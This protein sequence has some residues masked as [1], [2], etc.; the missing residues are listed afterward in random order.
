MVESEQL[1]SDEQVPI[2]MQSIAKLMEHVRLPIDEKTGRP[3]EGTE[4][5]HAA[6][7]DVHTWLIR[8]QVEFGYVMPVDDDTWARNR[9]RLARLGGC[10]DCRR[11]DG[12]VAVNGNSWGICHAHALR[13]RVRPDA[14]QD[15]FVPDGTP[16]WEDPD[17]PVRAYAVVKA[18]D[19][20][21][22]AGSRTPTDSEHPDDKP[23]AVGGRL[24]LIYSADEQ[25]KR[26]QLPADGN[27][28]LPWPFEVLVWAIVV[29]SIP[30][31]V[32]TV[33]ALWARDGIHRLL[34]ADQPTSTG[35]T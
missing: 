35:P 8:L 24:K 27:T 28:P 13:W 21:S 31:H 4:D 26:R 9:P 6:Y 23:F 17:R 29:V 22:P 1:D 30:K 34:D 10:P 18:L 14:I 7:Q 19:I 20:V 11:N 5:A 32:V 25:R 16:L 2:P 15:M 33:M 3:A 12:Y